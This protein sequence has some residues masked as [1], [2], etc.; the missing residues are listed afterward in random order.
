[1][2]AA[3]KTRRAPPPVLPEAFCPELAIQHRPLAEV[4]AEAARSAL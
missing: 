3:T 2:N 1:M 4:L